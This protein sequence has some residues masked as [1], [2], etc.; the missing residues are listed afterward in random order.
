MASTRPVSRFTL[1]D[2]EDGE[3]YLED[4]AAFYY[5]TDVSDSVSARTKRK[6]RLRLCTRSV[7]FEPNEP[8]FP[9]LRLPLKDTEMV[10]RLSLPPTSPL[11]AIEMCVIS[12][13]IVVKMKENNVIAPYVVEKV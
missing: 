8:N 11:A 10:A 2:I 7:V 5:P 12:S 1:L 6:G 4:F 13:K 3:E 9:L